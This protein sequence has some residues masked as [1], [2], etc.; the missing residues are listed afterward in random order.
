M[1]NTAPNC[2]LTRL[3]EIKKRT[4]RREKWKGQ[5]HVGFDAG[6]LKIG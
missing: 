4:D 2:E 1:V 5:V 6:E 3:T